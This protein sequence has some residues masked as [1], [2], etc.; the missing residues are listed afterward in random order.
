MG[1]TEARICI[2]EPQMAEFIEKLVEM[3]G[4]KHAAKEAQ[5]WNPSLAHM[6]HVYLSKD[7]KKCFG[8]SIGE[9]EEEKKS[10]L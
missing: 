7:D 4:S 6:M 5:P 3:D 10:T 8:R 1:E 9:K 2:V